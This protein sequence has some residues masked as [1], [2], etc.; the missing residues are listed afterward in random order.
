M[1]TD[2]VSLMVASPLE[3]SLLPVASSIPCF[4]C[5]RILGISEASRV[6][7]L[8]AP[9]PHRAV[10]G[11]CF[12]TQYDTSMARMPLSPGQAKE[13]ADY[14]RQKGPPRDDTYTTH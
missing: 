1:S 11:F 8:S 5:E 14:F 3:E 6:V 13:L 12:L 4:H 10:C 7:W 2:G 9:P